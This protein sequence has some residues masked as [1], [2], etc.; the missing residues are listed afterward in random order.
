MK[1][2]SSLLTLGLLL[3]TSYTVDAME[4]KLTTHL[5]TKTRKKPNV[6]KKK[7]HIQSLSNTPMPYTPPSLYIEPKPDLFPDENNPY[8]NEDTPDALP[9]APITVEYAPQKTEP[10]TV[11]VIAC[12]NVTPEKTEPLTLPAIACTDT[13]PEKKEAP[14]LPTAPA[15]EIPKIVGLGIWTGLWDT[16]NLAANVQHEIQNHTFDTKHGDNQARVP[17]VLKICINSDDIKSIAGIFEGLKKLNYTV[18]NRQRM[19]EAYGYL[20]AKQIALEKEAHT[21]ILQKATLISAEVNRDL[22]DINAMLSAKISMLNAKMIENNKMFAAII[23]NRQDTINVCKQSRL[24]C[25]AINEA[26]TKETDGYNSD[27]DKDAPT[28]YSESNVLNRPNIN[29][30][31][32]IEGTR[33]SFMEVEALLNKAQENIKQITFY[34][35]T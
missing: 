29:L 8:K 16:V 20:R 13:T 5:Q 35:T 19:A 26:C 3:I 14:S 31:H 27:T 24:N 30:L 4:Q 33:N 12:A 9:L 17:K 7:P 21:A 28:Q 18:E 11:P 23:K 22:A 15:K 34:R 10:L 32:T 2:I 1:N 25:I 6:G